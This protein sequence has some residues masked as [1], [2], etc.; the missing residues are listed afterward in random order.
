MSVL[1]Q[2]LGRSEQE[3]WRLVF[4]T[5]A[6]RLFVEDENQQLSIESFLAQ[7]P[8]T[9]AREALVELFIDMF[10]NTPKDEDRAADGDGLSSVS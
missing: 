10:P 8:A 7:T 4:D 5:D 6:G 1:S 9:E 3:N 2:K